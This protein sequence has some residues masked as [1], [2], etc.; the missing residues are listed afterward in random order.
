[1][2]GDVRSSSSDAS[3]DSTNSAVLN[4]GSG[5]HMNKPMKSANQPDNK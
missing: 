1:M 4:S 2:D 3:Y 5:D